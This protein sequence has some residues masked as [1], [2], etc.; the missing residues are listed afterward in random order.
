MILWIDG[1]S[2]CAVLTW[3]DLCGFIQLTGKIRTRMLGWLGF[4]FCVLLTSRPPG[5]LR[6]WL[7]SKRQAPMHIHISVFMSHVLLAQWLKEAACQ[8]QN[9]YGRG[10]PKCQSQGGMSHWEPT[11]VS[12]LY[13]LSIPSRL[14]LIWPQIIVFNFIYASSHQAYLSKGLWALIWTKSLNMSCIFLHLRLYS[15]FPL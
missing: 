10:L 8:A 12:P 4:S 14:F 5:F 11:R 1:G 3:W 6:S 9:Q 13:P 15:F 7:D 2:S